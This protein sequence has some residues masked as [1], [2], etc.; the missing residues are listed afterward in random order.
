MN[1]VLHKTGRLEVEAGRSPEFG[2]IGGKEEAHMN[3]R[4]SITMYIFLKKVGVISLHDAR[5]QET[6]EFRTGMP[7]LGRKSAVS[8][9]I[10]R[11][12]KNWLCIYT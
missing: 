11:R 2:M 7:I 3:L 10:S 1:E 12:V 4:N 8:T 9:I 6:P 5:V